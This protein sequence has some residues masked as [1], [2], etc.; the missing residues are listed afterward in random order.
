MNQRSGQ[1]MSRPL[2]RNFLRNVHKHWEIVIFTSSNADYCDPILREI[3]QN[4]YI[5]RRFYR[6]S[7][8]DIEGVQVKDLRRLGRQTNMAKVVIVDDKAHNFSLHH[9]N[10]IQIKPWTIGDDKDRELIKLE[11]ILIGLQ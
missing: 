3:D 6:E 8:I 10:G 1:F 2:L 11:R 9:K 5:S 4:G 7:C